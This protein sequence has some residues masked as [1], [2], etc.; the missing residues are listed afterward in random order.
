V[1]WFLFLLL[2]AVFWLL[3]CI[4]SS[5]SLPYSSDDLYK[6]RRKDLYSLVVS[7]FSLAALF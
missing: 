6:S 5:S 2:V 4:S 7:F 1:P 3:G